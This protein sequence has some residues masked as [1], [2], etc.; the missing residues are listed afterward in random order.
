M[1]VAA[2]LLI[3]DDSP[4][5][6]MVLQDTFEAKGYHVVTARDG[7][8]AVNEVTHHHPDLVIS[9]ILM[10]EL[11]GYHLCRLLKNDPGTATI[12]IILLTN[13]TE[14]HNHFWGKHAGA[15][16]Y[17]EKSPDLAP[18]VAMVAK[19]LA[20]HPPQPRPAQPTPS[21][22]DARGRL[23]ALLDRLLYESAISNDVLRLTRL[24]HNIDELA[25]EFLT[26]L[27]EVVRFNC[28]GL[29]VREGQGRYL[30]SLLSSAPLSSEQEASLR[31]L[32]IARI[33]S[34]ERASATLRL[35]RHELCT[36]EKVE[37][38][39]S[40]LIETLPF[41]DN[42]EEIATLILFGNPKKSR[43]EGMR[44]ALETAAQRFEVVMGYVARYREVDEVK[45]DFVSM[46]V[47]DLRVPLTS[48]RGFS[49][50]L[51]AEMMGPIN[52]DQS[53]ALDKVIGSCDQMLKLIENIL[54]ISRLEA[55][56]MPCHPEPLQFAPLCQEVVTS[57]AA[58]LQQKELTASVEIEDNLPAVLADEAQICR[59]LNN[60]L[61]NAIKF[62]PQGGKIRLRARLD[63]EKPEMITVRL[64][65]NGP[66]IPDE[67]RHR[68]FGH[69]QQLTTS[70]LFRKGTGLGLAICREIVHLH[71][72]EIWLEN[73]EDENVGSCFSFTLPLASP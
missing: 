6:L 4:T 5:T 31:P 27:T 10:P 41:Y 26:F 48:I 45:K 69:Y 51:G 61:G 15:N 52:A 73:P 8:A 21:G 63:A 44:H 25:R 58:L 3:V 12:P 39:S 67:L 49:D 65:D 50:V 23:T 71:G 13:L 55:G 28:A 43:S 14:R 56:K 47:H 2:T 17:I 19:L 33:P 42:N 30:L 1:T 72:G 34:E 57:A 38:D 20:E 68:L 11:N 46:L 9:D 40:T 53:D 37:C 16:G 36:T 62:T 29:L 54:D 64:C 24:A 32:F 60:L 22:V 18:L 7:I 70:P 66:G 59:V 35:V